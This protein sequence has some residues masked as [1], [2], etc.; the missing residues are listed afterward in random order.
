MY[1]CVRD[2][3]RRETLL[4]LCAPGAR[5]LCGARPAPAGAAAG[6]GP[7]PAGTAPSPRSPRR[8]VGEDAAAAAAGG[9]GFLFPLQEHRHETSPLFFNTSTSTL[10]SFLALRGVP[11]LSWLNHLV[12]TET[13]LKR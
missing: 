1:K 12:S 10:F 3:T 9:E 4:L 11:S 7:P 5:G 8:R 13:G 6:A 2:N